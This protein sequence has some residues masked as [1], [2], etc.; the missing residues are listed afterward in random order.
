MPDLK[1]YDESVKAHRL[2]PLLLSKPMISPLN[3]VLLAGVLYLSWWKMSV[4]K[5]ARIRQQLEQMAG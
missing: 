4:S 2:K 1:L 3:N 5:L